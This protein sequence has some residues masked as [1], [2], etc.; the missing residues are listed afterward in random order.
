MLIGIIK[1]MRRD[2]A[3]QGVKMRSDGREGGMGAIREEDGDG[4]GDG[5]DE[6]ELEME[7]WECWRQEEKFNEEEGKSIS[8]GGWGGD[9]DMEMEGCEEMDREDAM[10]L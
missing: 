1:Q 7:M 8:R 3:M 9:V 2:S 6:M 10:E 5:D 4:D